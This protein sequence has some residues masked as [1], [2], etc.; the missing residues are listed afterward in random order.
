MRVST[1]DALSQGDCRSGR[2]CRIALDLSERACACG[3]AA[4]VAKT[5]TFDESS[6]VPKP[7]EGGTPHRSVRLTF[8]STSL[9]SAPHYVRGC[10]PANR[11]AARCTLSSTAS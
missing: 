6:P 9:A 7:L 11:C 4:W 3:R 1:E 10:P 5:A 8:W 2:A